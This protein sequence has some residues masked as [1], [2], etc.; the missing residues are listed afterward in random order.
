MRGGATQKP[1]IA[2]NARAGTKPTS[3]MISPTREAPGHV[4]G[5]S[6]YHNG[7]PVQANGEPEFTRICTS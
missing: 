1:P 4:G 5:A 7:S 3:G 6:T 2:E